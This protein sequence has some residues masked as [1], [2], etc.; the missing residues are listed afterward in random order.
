MSACGTD[1]DLIRQLEQVKAEN[2]ALEQA[3][4]IGS[5]RA[6]L[7]AQPQKCRGPVKAGVTPQ[8][9]VDAALLRQD[10]AI[11]R[12]NALLKACAEFYDKV[13]KYHGGK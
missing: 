7:P 8:M 4:A 11:G 3:V 13:Q 10:D 5:Q 6:E 2:A 1:R 12:A 9:R